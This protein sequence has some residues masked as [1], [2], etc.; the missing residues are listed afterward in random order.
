[1]KSIGATIPF[2]NVWKILHV[3]I[4]ILGIYL[5][6][7]WFIKWKK[8]QQI[9]RGYIEFQTRWRGNKK[10]GFTFHLLSHQTISVSSC[11]QIKVWKLSS[12]NMSVLFHVWVIP[13]K[14]LIHV[15]FN[16]R[17]LAFPHSHCQKFSFSGAL[18]SVPLVQSWFA[19]CW[20]LKGRTTFVVVTLP[21][22]CRSSKIPSKSVCYVDLYS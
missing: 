14:S 9:L 3:Y 19:F 1:M 5:K 2:M 12:L 8:A 16:W 21:I 20:H 18:I 17:T 11:V 10:P 7:I 15:S 6:E 13:V 4:S 22:T